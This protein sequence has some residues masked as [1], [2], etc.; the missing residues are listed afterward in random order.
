MSAQGLAGAASP[1]EPDELDVLAIGLQDTPAGSA[2]LGLRQRVPTGGPAPPGLALVLSVRGSPHL[3]RRADLPAVRAA[4]RPRDNEALRSWL[5]GYGDELIASGADGP[6]LVDLVAARM[7]DAFPGDTATKGELSAAVT[8]LLPEVAR[9]WCESCGVAHVAEGLFRLGTLFAGVELVPDDG[10][11]MRLRL[12]SDEPTVADAGEEAM[13]LLLRS[14][15]RLAGPVAPADLAAWLDTR[16]V[17]ALPVW[18][19]P[20]V[21]EL[22]DELVLVRIDGAEPLWAHPEA[23]AAEAGAPRSASAR[24]LPPRDAYLLGN[25]AFL[26]PDRTV[27]RTV[28]RALGSPGVVV[29][30]GEVA[31]TW[32]QRASG[33]TLRIAVTAHRTLTARQRADVVEQ[34]ELVAGVRG[35]GERTEVVWEE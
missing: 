6:A 35:R 33:R 19:K 1:A 27:A 22:V 28:W 5:G 3:H 24:L 29:V 14:F 26:V 4:L 11:V 30:A 15:V 7:R 31:G 21:D 23:V 10:R 17:K 12:A 34:G 2:S 18:L 8:P 32:R 16:P 20:H 25:R 13:T 9:P